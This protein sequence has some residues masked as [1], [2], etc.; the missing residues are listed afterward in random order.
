MRARPADGFTAIVA[1]PTCRLGMRESIDGT[2]AREIVFLPP[3]HP[4]VMTESALA[5]CF[6]QEIQHW[7]KN[8]RH[9]PTIPLE[10]HGTQFQRRVW[11]LIDA[12]PAGQTRRYGELAQTL[13]SAARAVGQ[14]CGSN[15]FPILTP[16][17]RVVGQRDVGGFAHSREDWLLST[18][19][20][21][22]TREA[23]LP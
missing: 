4:L 20:W 15:P 21:L 6:A 9:T 19:H 2:M 14:A 10:I 12:I 13:N 22:L 11:Q 16:C 18:K 1:L 5:K 23:T 8:A 17:H 3:E 7:L